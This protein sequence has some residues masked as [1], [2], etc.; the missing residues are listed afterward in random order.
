MDAKRG[1]LTGRGPELH[2]EADG[3]VPSVPRAWDPDP[4]GIALHRF[5]ESRES[6]PLR[7]VHEPPN[8][9]SGV[10]NVDSVRPV[11]TR[12]PSRRAFRAYVC[13][14]A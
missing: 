3:S 4:S 5:L 10:V 6:G 9:Q 7:S 11:G 2:L 1:A 13:N 12:C 14:R 8:V